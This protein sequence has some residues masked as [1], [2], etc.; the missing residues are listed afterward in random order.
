MSDLIRGGKW[1]KGYEASDKMLDEHAK[2]Y[3]LEDQDWRKGYWD[4]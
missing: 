4:N 1:R 2:K 3:G